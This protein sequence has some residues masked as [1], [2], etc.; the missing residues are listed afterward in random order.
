MKVGL[1]M[2]V[3]ALLLVGTAPGQKWE[4][5]QISGENLEKWLKFVRPSAEESAWQRIRWHGELE[6]AAAEAKKLQRPILLWTMN[7]HPCGE[8]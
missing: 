2:G 3:C 5:P 4:A 6:D 1:G 7:G 8:T